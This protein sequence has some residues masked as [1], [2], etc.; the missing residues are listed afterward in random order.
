[1]KLMA[2]LAAL[3]ISFSATAQVS[4]ELT[5]GDFQFTPPA[6]VFISTEP[7]F[8][9]NMLM[10]VGGLNA[11]FGSQALTLYSLE[12]LYPAPGP[13]TA[14]TSFE[15]LGTD[16]GRLFSVAG[17]PTNNVESGAIQLAI[18]ELAGVRNFDIVDDLDGSWALAQ[19]YLSDLGT[20][21]EILPVSVFENKSYRY[22]IGATVTPIPEPGTYGLMMAGLAGIALLKVRRRS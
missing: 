3:V 17:T 8:D 21:S 9:D 18:W 16:F 7:G 22:Y 2:A 19:Q 1:M 11:T 20:A 5:I 14:Y 12:L 10:Q 15:R 4:D 6:E 13:S